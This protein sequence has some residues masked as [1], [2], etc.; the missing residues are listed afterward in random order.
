MFQEV[1]ATPVVDDGIVF[2]PKSVHAD[3]IRE[4]NVYGAVRIRLMG[5][6]GTAEIPVQV[7]VGAG[8]AVTPGE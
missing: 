8:D 4:D 7:D 1:T 2:D 3:D 5:K 6:L